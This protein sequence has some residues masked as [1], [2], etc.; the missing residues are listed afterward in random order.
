MNGKRQWTGVLVLI[1]VLA[2]NVSAEAVSTKRIDA[3][4]QKA[5]LNKEMLENADFEV[6]DA[7]WE[8]ALAELLF[9]ENP[10]KIVVIRSQIF[11]QG[12]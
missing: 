6:I 10:S 12:Q 1:S 4:R 8:E 2:L 3:V 11:A 9:A 5:L 7:F